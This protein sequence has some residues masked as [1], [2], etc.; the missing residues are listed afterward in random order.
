MPSTG[1]LRYR[2]IQGFDGTRMRD[3]SDSLQ[4]QWIVIGADSALEAEAFLY[5]EGL[6]F[7]VIDFTPIGASFTT[8]VKL[9][10]Y[11]WRETVQ[12]G[13]YIFTADYAFDRLDTDEYSLQIST[14]GGT[15]RVTSSFGTTRYAAP[16]RTAP[17]F[18][19]AIDVQEGKPQGIDRVIPA[20]K[21]T[22]TYRL[23]RPVDPFAFQALSS[24]LVG[25]V[26][27]APLMG[28]AA[29]EMLYLGGDGNFGNKIDPELQFSWAASSNATLTIG[30]ITGIAKK[31]HDYL[32]LIYED[33]KTGS[34][35]DT[36][37]VTKPRA[38]YVERIYTSGDHS[39]LGLLVS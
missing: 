36:Y 37:V 4:L 33:N 20:T 26:N 17:D 23:P 10:K 7:N 22:L 32:W 1:G 2:Q 39:L 27:T 14:G 28:H 21:M 12:D 35:A 11:V 8:L 31:G 3:G 15:I 38:A 24:S 18:V 5:S 25:T 13:A 34:G 19:S 29:G 30:G 16:S 6:P 9:N